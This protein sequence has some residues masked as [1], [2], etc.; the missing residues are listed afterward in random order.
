M[1]EVLNMAYAKYAVMLEQ[2]VMRSPVPG[3]DLLL[4]VERIIRDATWDGET[5]ISLAEIKRRMRQKAPRHAQVRDLADLLVYM[6]RI[7]ET[8]AGVEYSFM[9]ADAG[10]R[11]GHVP[12]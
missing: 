9:P 5:P 11:L 7:S 3:T 4:E 10:D 1:E 8:P 12:I 6:G 2:P